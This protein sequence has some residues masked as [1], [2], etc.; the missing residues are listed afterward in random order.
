MA[1]VYLLIAGSCEMVW[2]IGFK[3]TNGFKDHAWAVVVTFGVMGLSFWLLSAAIHHGIHVGNAYAIWTGIGACGTAILGM[4][5]F[6][7]PRDSARLAFIAMIVL[8]AV[9]LKFVSPPRPAPMDAPHAQL[10]EAA[11]DEVYHQDTSC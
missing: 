11:N 8:G 10:R 4:V 6:Q 3:Y 7:E 1:W 2:P 5:L 9:G